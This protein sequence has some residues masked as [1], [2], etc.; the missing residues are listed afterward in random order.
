MQAFN[1]N[2]E[3]INI[4]EFKADLLNLNDTPVPT[5]EEL[6]SDLEQAYQQA[7]AN[8][9]GMSDISFAGIGS[10]IL[11]K[12]KTFVCKVVGPNSSADDIIDAVLDAL[13]TILP[14][15]FLLKPL[16]KKL[17][18]FIISTGINA[19]CQVK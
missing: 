15:G 14:G 2:N 19:F 17:A 6:M 12:V 5:E 11:K 4:N 9:T 16:A 10:I 8:I 13:V 18:K 7:N 1:E 3:L